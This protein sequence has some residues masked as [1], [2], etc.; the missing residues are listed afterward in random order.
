MNS[1]FKVY[2]CGVLRLHILLPILNDLANNK[3]GI[4]EVVIDRL[5]EN[6]ENRSEKWT[7]VF[8]QLEKNYIKRKNIWTKQEALKFEQSRRAL[9]KINCNDRTQNISLPFSKRKINRYTS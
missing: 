6:I 8:T 9:H 3:I 2:Y 4:P 7:N 5:S 1:Y